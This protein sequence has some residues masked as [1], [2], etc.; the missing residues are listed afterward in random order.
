MDVLLHASPCHKS[1]HLKY[2]TKNNHPSG[3]KQLP[4][5]LPSRLQACFSWCLVSPTVKATAVPVGERGKLSMSVRGFQSCY[6]ATCK[7]RFCLGCTCCRGAGGGNCTNIRKTIPSRFCN[8]TTTVNG[9]SYGAAATTVRP[10]SPHHR[11]A[12]GLHA[13]ICY[14]A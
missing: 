5:L 14:A 7:S 9:A 2:V 12:V 8:V 10:S 3:G 6:M 13:S 1:C 4:C 11:S